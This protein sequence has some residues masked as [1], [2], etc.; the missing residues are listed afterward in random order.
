MLDMS[1]EL[2][3][4]LDLVVEEL[5]TPDPAKVVKLLS[6]FFPELLE[7]F[8]WVRAEA[9][10]TDLVARRTVEFVRREVNYSFAR[11]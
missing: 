8:A 10:R 2:Q 1:T 9:L 6:E 4:G 7:E 3:A 5:E 11:G